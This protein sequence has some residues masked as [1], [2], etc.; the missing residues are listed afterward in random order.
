VNQK[1]SKGQSDNSLVVESLSNVIE[2]SVVSKPVLPTQNTKLVDKI[3]EECEMQLRRE[4]LERLKAEKLEL[5][6]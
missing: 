2:P 1:L 6:R 3:R 4:E 5:I